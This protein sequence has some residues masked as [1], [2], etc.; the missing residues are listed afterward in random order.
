L[1]PPSA[2]DEDLYPPPV[3]GVG[4]LDPGLERPAPGAPGGP[5]LDQRRSRAD[6]PR[7][8]DRFRR[9]VLDRG[10][11]GWA[12]DGNPSFVLLGARVP[13]PCHQHHER[14]EDAA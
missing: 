5:K 4:R 11:A 10:V 1:V 12:P 3:A 8:V 2:R 7:E 9:E 14:P 6:E 13:E